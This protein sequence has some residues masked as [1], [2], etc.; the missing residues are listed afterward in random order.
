MNL[1][2]CKQEKN[3]VLF[4]NLN[5]LRNN[6]RTILEEL[7]EGVQLIPV[8]KGNAYGLGAAAVARVLSEFSEIRLLLRSAWR[9][10]RQKITKLAKIGYFIL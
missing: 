1:P 4:V 7:D 2:V 5:T 3:S 10:T 8:L 9:M 6:V